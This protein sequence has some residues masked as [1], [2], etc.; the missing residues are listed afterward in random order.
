MAH[1]QFSTIPNPAANRSY[2]GSKVTDC[3]CLSRQLLQSAQQ[4]PHSVSPFQVKPL[5]TLFFFF[6][7]ASSHSMLVQ[8]RGR[9]DIKK[10]QL[11]EEARNQA[12]A[13]KRGE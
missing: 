6:S 7:S 13:G 9:G 5:L 3:H 2:S 11:P 10:F 8:G 1:A 4:D 12:G